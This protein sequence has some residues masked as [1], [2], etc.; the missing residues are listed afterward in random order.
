MSLFIE[1][2]AHFN[3]TVLTLFANH[4]GF[5]CISTICSPEIW[6]NVFLKL[7][8]ASLFGIVPNCEV[9]KY[10]ASLSHDL[11]EYQIQVFQLLIAF[12]HFDAIDSI[13]PM[14]NFFN[15]ILGNDKSVFDLLSETDGVCP[16]MVMRV[17]KDVLR[18]VQTPIDDINVYRQILNVAKHQVFSQIATWKQ[19]F[20]T[21]LLDV[22]V[23]QTPPSTRLALFQSEE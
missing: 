4:D 7:C 14:T 10:L 22:C 21:N 3:K 9:F 12:E 5:H 2:L 16:E 1:R 15:H 23:L 17:F 11:L 6:Q 18:C 19:L 8:N 13:F 20:K